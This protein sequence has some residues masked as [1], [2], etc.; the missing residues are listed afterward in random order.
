MKKSVLIMISC[1]LAISF[2]GQAFAAVI[3]YELTDLGSGSF[4]Y[5][6]TVENNTL[7]E[8]LKL[9]T[10]WF[11]ESLY[12]NLVITS[13]SSINTRWDQMI[14]QS[15]GFGIPLGYDASALTD[16]IAAGQAETGFSVK[17]DWQGIDFPGSQYYEVF[18]PVS[19]ELLEQGYTIPEPATI[20]LLTL[21]SAFLFRKKKN[22]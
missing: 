16:G 6:Y 18:D 21:G 5:K 20:M 15:S 4:R 11:D 12:S 14:L 7:N 10:L 19:F 2:S 9:F 17:F 3:S 8:P 1:L 13:P 22:S